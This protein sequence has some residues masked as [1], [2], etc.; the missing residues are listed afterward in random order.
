MFLERFMKLPGVWANLF[1]MGATLLSIPLFILKGAAI[2]KSRAGQDLYS[3]LHAWMH[4]V[5]GGLGAMRRP[6]LS[7]SAEPLTAPL[8]PLESAVSTPAASPTPE[9]AAAVDSPVEP[10]V[11]DPD[12]SP[13]F[14]IMPDRPATLTDMALSVDGDT[15]DNVWRLLDEEVASTQSAQESFALDEVTAEVP[16][17]PAV[18][19]QRDPFRIAGDELQ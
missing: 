17:Q 18:A 5:P 6:L 3:A 4:R 10:E 19:P 15:K 12:P 16:A 1:L 11:I 2:G 14:T 13:L 9:P 7:A 8:Q